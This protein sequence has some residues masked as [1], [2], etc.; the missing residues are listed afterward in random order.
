[1]AY[2]HFHTEEFWENCPPELESFRADNDGIRNA[3]F[4]MGDQND[5]PPTV[6]IMDLPPGGVL[7]HHFHNS[8]RVEI[9]IRGEI[10]SAGSVFRAGDVMTARQGEAYGP[11]PVAGPDWATTAEMF[12]NYRGATETNYPMPDGEVLTVDLTD[13]DFRSKLP[14]KPVTQ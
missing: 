14:P 2:H 7:R 13:P 8:E 4:L 10:H 3:Y 11:N 12:S 1:M 9:V 6:M 5:N